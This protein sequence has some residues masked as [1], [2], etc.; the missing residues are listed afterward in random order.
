M[1]ILNKQILKLSLPSILANITIPIVGIVDIAIAGH[2]SS[3]LDAT[4]LI[5]GVTIGSML[6]DLLYW[7]FS[8]LRA[9]TGGLTAQ[10]YGR[11]DFAATAELLSRSLI[12]ATIIALILISLQWLFIDFAFLFVKASPDV[13]HLASKYFF[14]RIWAAPATL[15]LMAFKGWFIGMQDTLSTMITDIIVVISNVSASILFAFGLFSWEGLSFEGIAWAT[16]LAQYIGLCTAIFILIYKYSSV[17]FKN[18]NF[19]QALQSFRT[20]GAA[21]FLRT[22]RDLFIRS[23]C[24]IGIYIGFTTIAARYG[25]QALAASAL[26]MKITLFF[27]FFTDGFAYAGE[28]LTGRYIGEGKNNMV[29]KVVVYTFAWAALITVIFVFINGCFPEKLFAIMTSEQSLI[30]F[31]MNYAFW[32][33]LI[34]IFACP[35]FVWDGIYV[36]AT[37]SKELLKSGLL[38]VCAFF[39]LWFS[40]AGFLG[41]FSSENVDEVLAVH[42]LMAAYFA[43]IL[44]R[45]FYQSIVYIA[46]K[47]IFRVLRN[48]E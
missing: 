12:I 32:L 7:N 34:P 6:F 15:S 47:G 11:K 29:D 4:I 19:T 1:N 24:F 20:S 42:I 46:R 5:G 28:A 43:H 10:A 23:L 13:Q 37:A 8:F 14:I 33:I 27:S 26:M 30:D 9:G 3:D 44:M 17:V 36:G 21:M 35:S 22:N 38:S 31:S 18:F 40:L 48:N 16:V 45:T 39:I 25:N 2:L 41:L